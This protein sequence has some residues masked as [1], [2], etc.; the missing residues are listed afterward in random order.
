MLAGSSVVSGLVICPV[1]IREV[2]ISSYDYIRSFLF[3]DANKIFI[4][5]ISQFEFK[6]WRGSATMSSDYKD[7]TTIDI[8]S[9]PF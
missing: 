4:Q 7:S 6:F 3:C 2:K 5:T 1:D 9:C 8:R